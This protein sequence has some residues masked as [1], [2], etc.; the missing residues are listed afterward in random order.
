MRRKKNRYRSD[1]TRGLKIVAKW[2]KSAFGLVVVLALVVLLS[3]ALAYSY[4]ALL[5]ASWLQVNEVEITGLKHLERKEILNFLGVPRSTNILTIKVS[6]LAKNLESLPWLQSAVVRLDPPGRMVVEVTER[7]PLAIVYTDTFFL[8]DKEG[9]LFLETTLEQSPGLPLLT[10]FGGL[11]L[12]EGDSLPFEPLEAVRSLFEALEKVKGW[13]PLHL[14]SECRWRGD[15]GFVL[16]TAQR[17]VPV[18][19]GLDDYDQKLNRLQ[20]VFAML[21]ERQWLDLVTRIDLDYPNRAYVEGS[22]PT[23][24]GI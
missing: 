7:E 17:A 4:H 14:I 23:P 15:E 1:R 11:G 10:G 13:L 3:A 22:F 5:D 20:R 21:M 18:Q 16:F 9:K 12:H 8:L 24:K 19:L 2:I 6:Q